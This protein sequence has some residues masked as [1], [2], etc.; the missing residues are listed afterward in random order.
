MDEVC[1]FEAPQFHLPPISPYKKKK[2]KRTRK[3]PPTV[4]S[5]TLMASSS[6]HHFVSIKKK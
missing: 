4:V 6:L 1:G 2:G 3:R 5:G